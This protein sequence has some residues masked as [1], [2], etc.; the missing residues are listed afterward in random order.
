MIRRPPRS[1]LF[2][3]TTLFRSP[4][5]GIDIFKRE[6]FVSVMAKFMGSDQSIILSTHEI[7]EIEKIVDYVFILDDGKLVAELDAEEMRDTEGKSIVE[8]IR[9]VSSNV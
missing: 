6:E 1:T 4:F 9:E 3:Y 7:D 5:N 8:K 2:P